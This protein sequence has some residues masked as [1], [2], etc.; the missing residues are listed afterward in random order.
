MTL[1]PDLSPP[2]FGTDPRTG[3][4]CKLRYCTIRTP[5][6]TR[7]LKHSCE[8]VWLG[9]STFEQCFRYLL[10]HLL[11]QSKIF[12]SDQNWSTIEEL[13]TEKSP[14][15]LSLLNRF[16][17]S[18]TPARQWGAVRP[19]SLRVLVSKAWV[20]TTPGYTTF[21]NEFFI[22]LI[23]VWASNQLA[24]EMERIYHLHSRVSGGLARARIITFEHKSSRR[25][26]VRSLLPSQVLLLGSSG[27]FYSRTVC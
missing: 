3:L 26:P 6:V 5:Q 25:F 24:N 20:V 23:V 17:F 18:P 7:I 11:K 13:T 16:Y 4:H 1:V 14:T 21:E 19:L 12:L 2:W 15:V 27:P 10:W 22:R 8:L 9:E